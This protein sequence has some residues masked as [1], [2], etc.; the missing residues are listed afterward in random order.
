ME[1]M[2]AGSCRDGWNWAAEGEAGKVMGRHGELEGRGMGTERKELGQRGRSYLEKK[3]I[4]WESL[5][6]AKDVKLVC[7]M[8]CWL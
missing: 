3:K 1:D 8:E 6:M 4:K 2:A 5:R 7:P